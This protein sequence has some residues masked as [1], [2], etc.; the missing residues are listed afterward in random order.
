MIESFFAGSWT[1]SYCIRLGQCA[2]SLA[3]LIQLRQ[4]T[5]D[6]V[7]IQQGLRKEKKKENDKLACERCKYTR[8]KVEKFLD[9]TTNSSYCAWNDAVWCTDLKKMSTPEYVARAQYLM[10]WASGRP[11]RGP[12]DQ[13]CGIGQQW[14]AH[15]DPREG[16]TYKRFQK[17]LSNSIQLWVPHARRRKACCRNYHL[18][19]QI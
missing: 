15:Q 7:Y 4:D 11:M 18:F 8:K 14:S 19:G 13:L 16:D 6:V 1:V 17:N 9:S 2:S 5:S 12:G 10:G 3:L